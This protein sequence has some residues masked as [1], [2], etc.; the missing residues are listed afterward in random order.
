MAYRR[1][2]TP[3]ESCPMVCALAALSSTSHRTPLSAH[4]CPLSAPLPIFL[5]FLTLDC[6]LPT[7][8]NRSASRAGISSYS[9][10]SRHVARGRRPER[11]KTTPQRA[12]RA[13]AERREHHL[14]AYS[15]SRIAADSPRP[16]RAI[17]YLTSVPSPPSPNC[18]H[19]ENLSP[20]KACP[21]WPL[22]V[23]VEP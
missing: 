13:P 8:D 16:D 4:A 12:P 19:R 2:A 22:Y 10:I 7:G 15:R 21:R 6:R 18:L 17:S 1:T 14:R 9:C 3:G 20:V 5:S 23:K 11:M